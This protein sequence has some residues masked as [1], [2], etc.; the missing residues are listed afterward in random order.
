MA[1][2]ANFVYCSLRPPIPLEFEE[3][4]IVKEITVEWIICKFYG[5]DQVVVNDSDSSKQ[6]W[7]ELE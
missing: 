7:H 5:S 6:R 2:V 4:K 3:K 1:L